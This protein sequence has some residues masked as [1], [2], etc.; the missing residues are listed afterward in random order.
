ML[1]STTNQSTFAAVKIIHFS[2]NRKE[3]G[4]R[5]VDDSEN[6]QFWGT[7]FLLW[8]LVAPLAMAQRNF[9]MISGKVSSNTENIDYAYV[10]FKGTNFR[11]RTNAEGIYHLKAPAG[12][13]TMVVRAI[14]Y[15]DVE[16]KIELQ[17][18]QRLQQD[19]RMK[20][21]TKALDE[22][23]VLSNGVGRVNKSAYN[24][25]AIDADKLQNTT[26]DIAHV[27]DRVSGVKLREE[28]G[29]GSAAQINLNGF[30]GK[31]VKIFMDGIPMEGA[32]S[33]F[34]IN[35]IP[36]SLAKQIEI[37]KG[38]VPVDFGGDAL[39]GAINIV[40]NQSS[41]TYV[42]ASYSYGSFNTHKSNLNFGWTSRNGFTIRLN[43]YQNYSDNDYK[44]KTKYLNVQTNQYSDE[45]RWFKRFH[46]RYHNEAVI[47]K[48][49]FV[50]KPWAD[51][52]L[53]GFSYTHEYNQ[54][55]NAN[56]MQIVFGGKLRKSYS[57]SPSLEYLKRNLF[58][59]NLN[60]SV[61]AKYNKTTT[62]NIDTLSRT[63]SWTGDF[64]NKQ[65][66]GEGTNTLAQFD[67]RTWYAVANLRYHIG[68]HHFF[69]LNNTYSNY[70]R[71]AK[72]DALTSVQASPD[73]YMPRR[74]EKNVLGLS[75]K[76]AGNDNWNIL[77]FGKHYHSHVKGPVS[78]SQS[79]HAEY[80]NKTRNTNALGY[81]LAGTYLFTKDFQGKV[82]Y[83][84]TS[85]LPNDREL[86]GDGDLEQG[87]TRVRPEKSDNV[88]LNLS[89]MHS[90]PTGHAVSLEAG[91]NYRYITDYIQRTINPK[92]GQAVSQNWGKIRGIGGDFTA[93][94]FYK[95]IFSIGG[96]F[97]YQSTRNRE[98]YTS[99]GAE[100]QIYGDRVPNIPYM[101]S[102][103]DATYN[104]NG[105]FGERN[106]LSI[107]YNIQYVH[108]FFRSWQSEGAK[109]V[110]P[111]QVSHDASLTYAIQNGR[112][113]ISLEANN[114]TNAL[115][116]DNFSLQKPGRSFAVKFRYFFYKQH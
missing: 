5:L 53:A 49:G 41:N 67:G 15:A 40:T 50:N 90:F 85:R 86:F 110:I 72:N 12:K 29:L 114:F 58:V 83:E 68:R 31:H 1:F 25:I 115:L 20:T 8:A 77:A 109:L 54:V 57:L 38:V 52:L 95:N 17:P 34:Q 92:S 116:Y 4:K 93:R 61:V 113:N 108:A 96:N 37:Y 100:S 71:K 69:T 62:N 27:L 18:R 94:Y 81:G 84:K 98:R 26:L 59:P 11:S 107:G 74:N 78:I 48:I 80:V 36:I 97:T 87:N 22:V 76:Y 112:Y 75:Y 104:I 111:R 45:A 39:G 23:V 3:M 91:F 2:D 46:D 42:D 64:V 6:I 106:N 88:N 21:D 66:K 33:S 70:L 30:T 51:R 73:M 32:G 44:V 16:K 89:Y 60:L 63:Y 56:L 9:S 55:Q 43:A 14:G 10:Y 102:N 35:N 24:A 65:I 13:Y 19:I 101:F 105:L 103:G 28:G 47:G 7:F 82:S 79:G 99:T